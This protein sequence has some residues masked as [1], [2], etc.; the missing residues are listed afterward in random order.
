MLKHEVDI[1]KLLNTKLIL[2]A[3]GIAVMLTGPA[4]A[5]KPTRQ[6]PQRQTITSPAVAPYPESIDGMAH[7]GSASNQFEH[8]HG[9]YDSDYG[10]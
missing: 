6:V 10:S 7:T 4:F 2:S 9:Y 3:L 1:M 5:Q 8:D